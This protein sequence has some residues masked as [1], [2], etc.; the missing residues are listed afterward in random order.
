MQ[1]DPAA[2]NLIADL[3]ADNLPL[4]NTIEIKNRL[5]TLVSPQ[6]IEAGKTGQMPDQSNQPPSPEQQAAQADAQ[7][8]QAQIEI[9]KQELQIKQQEFL[10]EI[11]IEKMKLQIAEMEL[12]GG[13]EEQRMRYLAE[14]DRTQSDNAIA[15][16]D[17]FVKLMTHKVD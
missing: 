12:A 8:K 11:E 4:A 10:A 17:N 15:H 3:Y 14:S 2:F 13:I 16:A 1:A 6:V 7:F 9:K 5:K